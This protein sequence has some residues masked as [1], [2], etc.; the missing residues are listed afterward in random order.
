MGCDLMK[1]YLL[2]LIVLLIS[3]MLVNANNCD[4]ALISRAVQQ[5]VD[6]G[7][8]VVLNKIQAESD[9]CYQNVEDTATKYFWE[10]REDFKG[11]F[12]LDRIVGFV[13]TFVSFL[14]AFLSAIFIYRRIEKKKGALKHG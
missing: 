13:G 11:V 6:R 5:E 12:Y 7:N 8:Q 9:M 10:L 4:P 3:P 2:L 14:L 1:K